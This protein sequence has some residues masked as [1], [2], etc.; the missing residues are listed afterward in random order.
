MPRLLPLQLKFQVE[1]LVESV[2]TLHEQLS[3]FR[4]VLRR[5]LDRSSDERSPAKPSWVLAASSLQR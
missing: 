3:R 1:L 2:L 4:A 5:A